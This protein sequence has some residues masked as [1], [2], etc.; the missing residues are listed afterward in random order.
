MLRIGGSLLAL[1]DGSLLLLR[2]GRY[3]GCLLLPR[4]LGIRLRSGL[5]GS[6]GSFGGSLLLLRHLGPPRLLLPRALGIRLRSGLLG[7]PGSLKLLALLDVGLSSSGGSWAL[8]LRLVL[9][10]AKRGELKSIRVTG[11]FARARAGA[12]DVPLSVKGRGVP[13][14]TLCVNPRF[15]SVLAHI[16]KSL[17]HKRNPSRGGAL[18]LWLWLCLCL[19]HCLCASSLCQSRA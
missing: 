17:T 15:P 3:L 1:L 7:I 9:D 16:L 6:P 2:L 14:D 18:C 13:E 12:V 5:L 19:W 4:A 11:L 8:L 10:I